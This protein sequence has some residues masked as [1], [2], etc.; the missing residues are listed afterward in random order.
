LN[1]CCSSR[2]CAETSFKQSGTI[3]KV[4]N[5]FFSV[6]SD[7]EQTKVNILVKKKYRFNTALYFLTIEQ[8]RKSVRE[9][10][11]LH[12]EKNAKSSSCSNHGS[13][14]YTARSQCL[15]LNEKFRAAKLQKKYEY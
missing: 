6:D 10:K 14:P 15:Y 7:N 12:N 2:L 9:K 8:S 5:I 4:V 13:S 3:I 1:Q 11:A